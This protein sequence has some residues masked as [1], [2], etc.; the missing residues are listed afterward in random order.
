MSTSRTPFILAHQQPALEMSPYV[1]F[2]HFGYLPWNFYLM[3]KAFEIFAHSTPE[4]GP[5]DASTPAEG[6]EAPA[7]A[8]TPVITPVEAIETPATPT[9]S[10]PITL[11]HHQSSLE[12]SPYT[13]FQ[14]RN[15][16]PWNFYLMK[17]GLE[18]FGHPTSNSAPQNA[19]TPVEAT[20][21][22]APSS[23]FVTPKKTV[24]FTER[25]GVEL[26]TPG[27]DNPFESLPGAQKKG[28]ED[29]KV[30]QTNRIVTDTTF[31]VIQEAR[32]KSKRGKDNTAMESNPTAPSPLTVLPM[33]IVPAIL[34][35]ESASRAVRV[36]YPAKEKRGCKSGGIRN[37]EGHGSTHGG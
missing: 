32:A 26:R 13:P 14:C 20:E 15:Y 36:N 34:D 11:P 16:L 30:E 22:L 6:G 21:A 7:L 35:A 23:T 17:K 8:A 4:S 27:S 33:E 25:T 9:P 12:M 18:V 19:F 1:P 29:C 2:Q 24:K 10:V 5:E 3:K 28:R 31:A 37:I